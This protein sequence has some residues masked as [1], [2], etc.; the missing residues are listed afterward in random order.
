MLR[1]LHAA[2]MAAS[3]QLIAIIILTPCVLLF[4]PQSMSC[5]DAH[6]IV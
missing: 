5:S 6:P 1:L 4:A 2:L 3:L